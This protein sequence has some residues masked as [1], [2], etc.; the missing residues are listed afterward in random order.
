MTLKVRKYR[1]SCPR[2]SPSLHFRLLTDLP[3]WVALN[4]SSLITPVVLFTH[5][6]GPLP[7]SIPVEA[8]PA[9]AGSAG[10]QCIAFVLIN[11][12]HRNIPIS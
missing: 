3:K 12:R 8:A 11:G 7:V 6:W 1:D 9:F 5:V 2:F 10:N 4:I